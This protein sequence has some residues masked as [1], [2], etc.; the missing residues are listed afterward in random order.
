MVTHQ[1]VVCADEVNNIRTNVCLHYVHVYVNYK[2]KYRT[3][4]IDSRQGDGDVNTKK[5]KLMF[6]L[7]I[8]PT[9]CT[10]FNLL[11]I[12][13]YVFLASQCE[14]TPTCRLVQLLCT[15]ILHCKS[16]IDDLTTASY[17]GDDSMAQRLF[18]TATLP[19]DEPVGP[20]ICRSF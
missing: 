3:C 15:Y 16:Y 12:Q 1:L 10:H 9:K 2:E 14:H 17:I 7:Q 20:K 13:N 6:M 8:R 19:D 11:I 4:L 5:T 18:C